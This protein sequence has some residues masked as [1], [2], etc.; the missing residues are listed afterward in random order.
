MQSFENPAGQGGEPQAGYEFLTEKE[1]MWAEMLMQ[2]LQGSDI[3]CT[4]L[5]V[6]GAGLVM[7]TGMRERLRVFVPAGQKAQAEEI[8]QSFSPDGENP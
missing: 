2:L 8:L 1:T 5:P 4:A 3:P 6:Y 7:R